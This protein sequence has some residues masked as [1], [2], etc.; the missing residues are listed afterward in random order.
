[1]S[2][3]QRN[4]TLQ[5]ATTSLSPADVLAAA[6]TFFERRSGIYSA[7][8]EHE[9]PTH[10]TLRGQ[11]GEEI[12]IGVATVNGATAVNGSSYMFDQQVALFLSSLP[13]ATVVAS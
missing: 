4:R 1:V 13:P 2:H 10:V 5:Q 12:A 8:V 11:G 6:R 9:G 3:N 7:F